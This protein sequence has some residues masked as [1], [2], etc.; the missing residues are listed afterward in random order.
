VRID[1]ARSAGAGFSMSDNIRGAYFEARC[2]LLALDT[3]DRQRIVRALCMEVCFS[4]AGGNRTRAR[5]YELLC[6]AQGLADNLGTP[7]AHALVSAAAGYFHYFLGEWRDACAW[8]ERA[9]ALF[10]DRC[11]G[12]TFELNSV[13]IMLYRALAYMGSIEELA[14]RVPPVFRDVEKQGDRYSSINLRAV[15]MMTV[16]LA[17]GDVDGVAHEVGQATRWLA[18]RFLV[19]HYFC[20]VAQSQIDLY[21]GDGG[22]AF[23]RMVAAWPAMKRSLLLRVQSI[24][25]AVVDQRARAALAAAATDAR[26]RDRLLRT[27]ERDAKQLLREKH[28]WATG[29]AQGIRAAIAHARGDRA[30]CAQELRA[31]IAGFEELHMGLHAAAMRARLCELLGDGNATE[32]RARTEAYVEREHVRDAPTM[33]ATLAPWVEPERR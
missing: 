33:F 11:V 32:L 10:R 6:T 7:E 9:E 13:R 29:L 1:T 21:R 5:T 28:P 18:S 12:V 23:D 2:L 15:P 4:A 22:A 8:L 16:G 30:R 25:I 31:A 24:R 20:L 26:R 17:H 27:A 3:S 19:Q 14:A